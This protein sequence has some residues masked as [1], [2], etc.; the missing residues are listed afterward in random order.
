MSKRR[1]RTGA[2]NLPKE[3]LERARRQA[4]IERGE[5]EPEVEE[6]EAPVVE[7]KPVRPAANVNPYR[8]VSASQRR[9]VSEARVGVRRDRTAPRVGTRSRTQELDAE[10]IAEL[11]D[12]PTITVTEDDLKRDYSYV[13]AD[14]RNMGILAAGL[15]VALVV[16]ATVLPR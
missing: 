10:T 6:I 13:V 2:P 5:I 12:N 16:L 15:I 7:E 14:L 11:L 3:T 8:T 9:A 1:N 4:A